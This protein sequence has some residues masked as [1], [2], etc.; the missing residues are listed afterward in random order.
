MKRFMVMLEDIMVAVAFAEEGMTFQVQKQK[1][2]E[3]K[4]WRAAC[5]Q[6]F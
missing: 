6:K 4:E 5:H 1:N 3:H 2:Y